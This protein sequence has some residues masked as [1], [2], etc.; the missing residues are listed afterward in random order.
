MSVSKWP[1]SMFTLQGQ[2]EELL[3]N[4]PRRTRKYKVLG[5]GENCRVN[6]TPLQ[7]PKY[8]MLWHI[9]LLQQAKTWKELQISPIQL[10]L[11]WSWMFCH[12]WHP[13]PCQ[14]SQKR[15]QSWHAWWMHLQSQICQVWSPR[16]RQCHMD[17]NCKISLILIQSDSL[18]WLICWNYKRLD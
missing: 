7:I 5:S 14:A 13:A 15:T 9:S 2:S 17:V 6:R 12:R 4:L 1:H 3:P 18:M 16:N 11:C 8:G 10:P